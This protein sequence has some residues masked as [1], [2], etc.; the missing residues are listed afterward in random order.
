M[1]SMPLVNF[2]LSLNIHGKGRE[3]GREGDLWLKNDSVV[4]LD[5]EAID[6]PGQAKVHGRQAIVIQVDREMK[7]LFNTFVVLVLVICLC[8]EI[9]IKL[10]LTALG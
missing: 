9:G 4:D 6:A 3:Q 5:M 1:Q 7:V 8:V 2:F 10:L